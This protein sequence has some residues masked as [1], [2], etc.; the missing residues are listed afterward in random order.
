MFH[1][2]KYLKA[3]ENISSTQPAAIGA[4]Q[5]SFGNTDNSIKDIADNIP[6]IYDML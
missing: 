5:Y 4:Y 3:N 2:A 1:L 6:N